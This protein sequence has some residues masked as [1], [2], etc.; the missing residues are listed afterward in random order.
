MTVRNVITDVLDKRHKQVLMLEKVHNGLAELEM[1]M[2]SLQQM[3]EEVLAEADE[4]PQDIA[5]LTSKIAT[6]IGGPQEEMAHLNA[7]IISLTKRF[8]KETINIGVAGKARQGK[9]TLLQK[10]SG[11][12]NKEIPTSDELPCTGTKSKIY[13]SEDDAYAK[14]EFYSKEEFLKE[15]LHPYFDKL[16]ISKPFSLKRFGEPLSELNNN[17]SKDRNLDK[18]IYEKLAFIHSAF[19]S[20]AE[21]LSKPPKTLELEEILNY[22]TQGKGR[23]RYLAVK[24]A[25]IY[26]K[27]PNH[28][29]TGLCLVDLPGLEAAQGHE[30]KLVSSLEHEVDAV[31]FVKSPDVLG[32]DW[33]Q[34]DYNVFDLVDN[35]VREVELANRLFIVL[36]EKN[37]GSNKKQVQLLKEQP[38]ET[39]SKPRILTADCSDAQAVEEKVFSVVLQHIEKKLESTDQQYIKALA[40]KMENILKRLTQAFTPALASFSTTNADLTRERKYRALSEQFI[41]DLT[42]GLEKLVLDVQQEL[43][44]SEEFKEKVEEICEAAKQNAPIPGKDELAEQYLEY[45]GWKGVVGE[46]L[47]YLRAYLTEFLATQLDEYLQTK[48]NNTLRQVLKRIFP[49]VLQKILPQNQDSQAEPRTLILEFQDLLD[50]AEHSN[51]YNTFSYIRKFNFSYHSHFHYRVREEMGLLS[52]YSSESVDDI[53]PNDATR[54]NFL[55]KAEEIS[56]GLDSHYQQT[57][58]QLRKKFSEKMQTDPAN[59]ILA[60]VEEAKDRLVRAKG[61]KDEWKSFL[62]PIREQLWADELSRFNKEIALRKQ[63][64]NALD[65]ALKCA[66]QIQVAFHN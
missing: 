16:K 66:Q 11:L 14:I 63:W 6:Y 12:S 34:A 40:D 21:L 20:Y 62:D 15:I 24:S 55:E 17:L 33:E 58:Y 51:I 1:Q 13:H 42:K 45:S 38:P 57:I 32:T 26:T 52:T 25:D 31:I 49:K 65:D 64:R 19:S 9:S 37:D 4:I 27:F 2:D 22:V 5:S 56:R 23:T 54:A 7:S 46:E 61:I 59:A 43:N 10:I 48:I 29:V 8:S 36:N 53:V 44:I 50:R 28:D 35:A 41:K 39:Y 3:A 18:A 30:M 60:L 47:N